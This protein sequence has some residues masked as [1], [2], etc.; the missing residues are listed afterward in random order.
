MVRWTVPATK[1]FPL[2]VKRMPQSKKRGGRNVSRET[3][4]KPANDPLLEAA[5]KELIKLRRM[6]GGHLVAQYWRTGD[7]LLRKFNELAEEH[8]PAAAKKLWRKWAKPLDTEKNLLYRALGLRI[9]YPSEMAA[10]DAKGLVESCK[11]MQVDKRLD[12]E[13]YFF[14]SPKRRPRGAGR[15]ASSGNDLATTRLG[16]N[17][18]PESPKD[19]ALELL[20]RL[21]NDLTK[22]VALLE[23]TARSI[24]DIN[25]DAGGEKPETTTT[26]PPEAESASSHADTAMPAA[27]SKRQ[28]KP[29]AKKHKGKK[30]IAP[31]R[32]AVV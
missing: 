30:N 24:K 27:G 16:L 5:K 3:S 23:E 28:A 1:L 2:G 8:G 10:A 20:F 29:T 12:P 17:P 21:G 11:L 19:L 25:P 4:K 15:R 26:R 13:K 18:L 6:D 7:V 14:A 31:A 9:Y 22:A 32:R